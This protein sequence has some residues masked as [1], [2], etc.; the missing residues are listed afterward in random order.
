MI[1]GFDLKVS[2]KKPVVNHYFVNKKLEI[3]VVILLE[4]NGKIRII[5]A[6]KD[7]KGIA[8]YG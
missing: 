4:V 1:R 6:H 7:E 8:E 2:I 5:M 3:S